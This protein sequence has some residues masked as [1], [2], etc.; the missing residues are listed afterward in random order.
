MGDDRCAEVVETVETIVQIGKR[1]GYSEDTSNEKTNSNTPRATNKN[2]VKA[3]I[4]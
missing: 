2:N 1:C 3:Y 4:H